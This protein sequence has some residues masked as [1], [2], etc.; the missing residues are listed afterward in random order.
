MSTSRRSSAEKTGPRSLRSDALPRVPLLVAVGVT[1]VVMFV[2]IAMS[3]LR[4]PFE[5]EWIEGVVLDTVQR[6]LAGQP[7][8]PPPSLD[9][10]PLNY[11]PLYYGVAAVVSRLLGGDFL[12]LR[13]VSFLCALG[14]MAL[15]FAMVRWETGSARAGTL[16]ATLFAATY[17]LAGAWFDV[18]RADSL[19]LVLLL[20]GVAVLRA[21]GSSVRSGTLGGVLFALAFLAKQSALVVLAPL[22]LVCAFSDRRRM[23][24]LALAA[25]VLVVGSTLWLQRTSHGWYLFY[26][27]DVPRRHAL[28]L[29]MAVRF[30]TA[31]LVGP[32][33]IAVVIGLL[34]LVLSESDL[35]RP[36]RALL[37]GSAAGLVGSSWILRMYIGG[38][39]NALMTA[40][41]AVALLFGM[42]WATVARRLAA[43]PPVTAAPLR[44][45]LG[46]LCLAQF[47]LLVYDPRRQVPSADDRV[48]GEHL[49]S[50]LRAMP[51][52]T[53]FPCHPYLLERGGKPGHF[54]E[55]AFSDVAAAGAHG[56]RLV[57]ELEGALASHRYDAVVLDNRDW[58]QARVD[59]SYAPRW[60]AFDRADVFWPVTGML[61]RPSLIETPRVTP[62]R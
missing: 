4:Y 7:L 54:H 31:D 58:L 6:V 25:G 13:L 47:A 1:Y 40:C 41:A 12:P 44:R 28:D 9:F 59:S 24:A 19:Y 21:V 32:L 8:Y 20:G 27:F 48:A 33:G 36:R 11:T 16:A 18:A 46:V 61:R 62:P 10:I 15:L 30:W 56:K 34:G 39:E 37:L 43:I 17:R 45:L 57:S 26:V 3:R 2:A 22:L 53:L 35:A 29:S 23:V 50:A 60:V 42:G 14:V 55:M 49:V 38:Y 52:E 51:G 5:L